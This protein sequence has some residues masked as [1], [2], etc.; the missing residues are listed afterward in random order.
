MLSEWQKNSSI[1]K[2]CFENIM[3]PLEICWNNMFLVMALSNKQSSLILDFYLYLNT[4]SENYMLTWE[5]IG[6]GSFIFM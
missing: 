4:S 5:M 1:K 3:V 2:V 6:V